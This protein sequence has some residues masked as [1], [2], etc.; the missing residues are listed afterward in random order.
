VAFGPVAAAIT[1]IVGGLALLVTG[2]RDAAT[3]GWNLQN[4]FMSMAGILATGAGIAILT[5]SWIPLLIAGIA[6]A[7]L[8]ITVATGHG[9]ELIAGVQMVLQGFLDFFTGLFTGDI[10]KAISGIGQVCDGLKTV[11]STIVTSLQELLLSFLDWLDEK[12]GGRFHSIIETAKSFV[13]AFFDTVNNTLSG[14]LDGVKQILTGVIEFITGVFTGNWDLAWQGVQDVFRGIWNTIVTILENGINFIIEG[15]NAFIRGINK[16]FAV[17]RGLLGYPP[18]IN[19]IAPVE[20]PRLATGAVIPPNREFMAV[21]GDQKS[22]NNIETPEA[23]LRKIVREESGSGSSG[24]ETVILECDGVQF[25]KLIY[26]LNKSEEKR[27]G[28]SLA[29][30]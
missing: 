27:R 18:A 13:N 10:E 17:I 12:T 2:F 14:I 4:L 15:I 6:S 16:A 19:E 24:E 8:A 25:A 23:L 22:G 21:L 26:K 28:M 11:I 9:E 5:G 20:L 7:L 3:N 29:E 1:L 30:V